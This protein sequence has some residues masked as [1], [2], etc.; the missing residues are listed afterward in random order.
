LIEVPS[1]AAFRV[2]MTPSRQSAAPE[3]ENQPNRRNRWKARQDAGQPSPV[4]D[5]AEHATSGK[6]EMTDMSWQR[7]AIHP[8]SMTTLPTASELAMSSVGDS[9]APDLP[10]SHRPEGRALLII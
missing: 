7:E 9:R 8:H 5:R 6:V 2:Q 10:V 4:R 3:T 1:A